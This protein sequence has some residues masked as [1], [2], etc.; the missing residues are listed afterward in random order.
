MLWFL[1]LEFFCLDF[2]C[3]VISLELPLYLESKLMRQH[4]NKYKT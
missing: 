4:V 3:R 1:V 2:I